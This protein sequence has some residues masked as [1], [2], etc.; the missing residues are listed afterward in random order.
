MKFFIS[1]I[2]LFISNTVHAQAIRCGDVWSVKSSEANLAL[3][4]IAQKRAQEHVERLVGKKIINPYI[5][6]G[7]VNGEKTLKTTASIIEVYWCETSS[8]PLHSSYQSLYT[9]GIEGVSY[10]F[11]KP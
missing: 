3:H 4:Q 7:I 10:F 5:N 2:L 9:S 1:I 8:T 6:M 11:G